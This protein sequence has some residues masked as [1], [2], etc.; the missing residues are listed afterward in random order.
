MAA[1]V[2]RHG[3]EASLL[4][5]RCCT[6]HQ[7]ADL[8]VGGEH[9][10]FALGAHAVLDEVVAQDDSFAMGGSQVGRWRM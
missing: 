4:P 9:A 5:T 10:A 8:T 3:L 6:L 7:T 2:E 1:P